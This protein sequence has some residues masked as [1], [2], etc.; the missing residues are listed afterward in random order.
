MN[1]I[2]NISVLNVRLNP[3][4][5][6]SA[7]ATLSKGMEVSTTENTIMA[8]GFI[9]RE[10]TEPAI[11]ANHWVAERSVDNSMIF[12][13]S[14]TDRTSNTSLRLTA[15]PVNGRVKIIRRDNH[16]FFTIDGVIHRSIG[17]NVRELPWFGLFRNTNR[18]RLKQYAEKAR[19]IGVKV[20]RFYAPLVDQTVDEIVT[21]NRQVL[22]LLQQHDLMGIVVL[23]D[24]LNHSSS[25][26]RGEE[27]WHKG[28]LGLLT[29]E[30]YQDEI[31]SQFY[32]PFVRRM[33]QEL[34][35][36]P[37]IFAWDLINEPTLFFRQDGDRAI[38]DTNVTAIHRD[39]FEQFVKASA[40]TIRAFD[41]QHL[42]TIGLI[43]TGQ[44]GIS[45]QPQAFAGNFFSAL[46]E[47]LDFAQ[48]HFYQKSSSSTE[49][50]DEESRSHV[51]ALAAKDIGIPIVVGEFGSW[52]QAQNRIVST[53]KMLQRW[54]T[55][56]GAAMLL[57][58]GF[59]WEQ[60]PNDSGVGD[61]AH[62]FDP[63]LGNEHES[64]NRF[65]FYGLASL[66]RRTNAELSQ[67]M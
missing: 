65:V 60:F 22:D 17:V 46:K 29:R 61:A 35:N 34:G 48:V 20:I 47:H 31:Y 11:F 56:L 51:D 5:S 14:R 62:G 27:A 15:R 44:L 2:V 39:S 4:T 52:S 67:Q 21:R 40:N 26:F 42:I 55:D 37:A 63:I 10:L 36:H 58:W 66:Y 12:L 54:V 41:K 43:N 19:E 16:A 38:Q 9:W 30:Y 13:L 25:W 59:M 7:I 3:T 64:T 53:E 18:D 28:A 33:A 8:E 50:W 1:Y 49:S 57:Q 45:N 24:A 6:S 23:N 32:L